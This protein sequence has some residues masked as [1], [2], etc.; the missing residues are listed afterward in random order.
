MFNRDDPWYERISSGVACQSLTV[1]AKGSAD[2][3]A[4]KIEM[5]ADGVS[6]TAVHGNGRTP[7]A[8]GIPGNFTVSNVLTVLGIA[9][10]LGICP[11]E[12]AEALKTAHFAAYI[13]RELG[14][15]VEPA[16]EE[17][18]FPMIAIDFCIVSA[19]PAI[20]RS[21][22]MRS[23]NPVPSKNLKSGSITRPHTSA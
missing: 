3:G 17:T 16:P 13:F 19:P 10:Q 21:F 7:V 20:I 18:R 11:E 23:R 2:L 22:I 4:E 9:A 6:F 1:S 15:A 14:F 5:R 8:V 12:A